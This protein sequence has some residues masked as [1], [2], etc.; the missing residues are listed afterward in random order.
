MKVIKTNKPTAF[1]V[2]ETLVITVPKGQ[3]DEKCI[4]INGCWWRPHERHIHQLKSHKARA[5]TIIVWSAG[6]EHWAEIVIKALGLESYVDYVM[7]KPLWCYDDNNQWIN[8]IEY[9]PY[10]LREQWEEDDA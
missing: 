1:D 10:D 8:W 5:H 3:V 4:S 9:Q 6:G 7:D 2:D